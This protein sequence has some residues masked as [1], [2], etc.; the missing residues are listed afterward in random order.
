MARRGGRPRSIHDIA[1]VSP[2]IL[3]AIGNR[4]PS[5]G[6]LPA[7]NECP[8]CPEVR[9]RGVI[10]HAMACSRGT[11]CS[12]RK[13]T[14]SKDRNGEA[15]PTPHRSL[16]F[17]WSLYRYP[18]RSDCECVSGPGYRQFVCR[19]ATWDILPARRGASSVEKAANSRS[20][21]TTP[22]GPYAKVV[23][24]QIDPASFR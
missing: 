21:A 15:A 7:V 14:G 4:F 13:A 24:P 11:D 22:L 3:F 17:D 12:S 20:S 6:L 23:G 19:S 5:P 1:G 18:G 9:K 2:V 8:A 10:K 16:Y